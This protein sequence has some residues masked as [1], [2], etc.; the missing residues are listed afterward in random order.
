MGVGARGEGEGDVWVEIEE[1]LPGP[2]SDFLGG[3]DD[4]SL[5]DGED[6]TVSH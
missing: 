5:V 2:G 3:F 6:L 1:A 4:G